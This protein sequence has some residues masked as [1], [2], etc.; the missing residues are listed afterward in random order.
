MKDLVG[1]DRKLRLAVQNLIPQLGKSEDQTE[2]SLFTSL[3][4]L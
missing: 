3:Q 2:A 4:N 1:Q